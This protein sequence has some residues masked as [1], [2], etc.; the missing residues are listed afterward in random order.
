[1]GRQVRCARCHKVWRAELNHSEKLVAAAATIAPHNEMVEQAV[2]S[3]ESAGLS[4]SESAEAAGAI[5]G[6]AA[7][8]PVSNWRRSKILRRGPRRSLPRPTRGELALKCR[9]RRSCRPMGRW[10]PADR[11]YGRHSVGQTYEPAENI[12]T[13]VA[14]RLWHSAERRTPRWPLSQVQTGSWR[15]RS[16]TSF[17]SVGEPT[18]CAPCRGPFVLCV[19]RTAGELARLN[20]Q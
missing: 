10:W 1:M 12:E 11:C 8:H 19:A 14:R 18:S 9:R 2:G 3:A 16:S 4:P 13:V 7:R 5:S 20:L 17:P 15:W 6:E